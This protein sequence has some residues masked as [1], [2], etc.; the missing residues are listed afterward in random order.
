MST[1]D[2][3]V[4]IPTYGAF[5]YAEAAIRSLFAN[6]VSKVCALLVDDASPD[7]KSVGDSV[8]VRLREEFPDRFYAVQFTENGGLTRSWN[9]GIE[10][11]LS[12]SCHADFICC[13]NSDLLFA[14]EWDKPL[15]AAA[16]K[17]ALVGPLTNTPGPAVHQLVQ[18][19]L[20]GY[21]VSD[22]PVD[23]AETARSLRQTFAGRVS[24]GAVNGFC[25]L[26]H[27]MTWNSGRYDVEHVFRPRNDHNSKGQR[28]PTPLMTL[29]EDELQQRWSKLGKVSV[30]CL[31]SFVFHYRSVSRGQKYAK[32]AWLRRA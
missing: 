20:L 27:C 19:R 16:E 23:I 6:S 3:G 32:G 17:Y 9:H 8:Y 13:A 15:L 24:V 18:S 10:Y 4:I 30:A 28:N 25:M 21:E 29:N 12:P 14:P 7:W 1:F 2:L 11:F 26:A 31:D 5:D 22:K